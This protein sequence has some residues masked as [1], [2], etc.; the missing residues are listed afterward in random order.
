MV[1]IVLQGPVQSYEDYKDSLQKILDEINS[2]ESTHRECICFPTASSSGRMCTLIQW[3]EYSNA[4]SKDVSGKQKIPGERM[5]IL[6]FVNIVPP[7]EMKFR[8]ENALWKY[9]ADQKV[10]YVDEVSER[11]FRLQGGVGTN[12]WSRFAELRDKY[13]NNK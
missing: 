8:L 1:E 6:Q 10:S 9:A 13:V 3:V 11:L 4:R 12:T 7:R 5:T 2:K